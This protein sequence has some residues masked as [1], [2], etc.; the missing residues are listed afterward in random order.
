MTRILHVGRWYE[1]LS[2]RSFYET[3]FEAI[4]E[5][6]AEPLFPGF[7]LVPFKLTVH[8][9]SMG[10]GR[11]DLALVRNDYGEWWVIEVELTSHSLFGH[12]IPQIAKFKTG[13]YTVEHADYISSKA[14][15]LD[16]N[17]LRIMMKG[18]PPRI[19]VVAEAQS[20]EWERAIDAN[21]AHMMAFEP[22]RSEDNR[23][24]FRVIGRFPDRDSD[25]V[26]TCRRDPQLP[27]MLIV[28]RPG[29]LIHGGQEVHFEIRCEDVPTPWRILETE[30]RV[31]L[32]PVGPDPFPENDRFELV[33]DGD[34]LTLR[35][36]P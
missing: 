34:Y 19:L 10:S 11:P 17:Q 12:V 8:A 24:L 32:V 9:D 27:S 7:R 30:T 2:H 15:D 21:G 23:N 25:L 18:E 1:Q 5:Q 4:V 28:D 14:P 6:N 31:W 33:R 36:S 26:S 29:A 16:P 13:E 20:M 35:V 22:F 3:E